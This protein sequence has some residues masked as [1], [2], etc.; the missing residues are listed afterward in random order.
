MSLNF[1]LGKKP[2]R[3]MG[4]SPMQRRLFT[5]CLMLLA[6]TL[7]MRTSGNERNWRWF[8]AMNGQP[9]DRVDDRDRKNVVRG[10]KAPVETPDGILLAQND[11]DADLADPDRY[12]PGVFPGYLESISDGTAFRA[13]DE[14]AWYHLINVLRLNDHERFEKASL[15]HHSYRQLSGQPR[16]F[17]GRVVTSAGT[18]RR[19]E[20]IPIG[21]NPYGVEGTLYRLWVF[22]DDTTSPLVVYALELPAGFPIGEKI[23]EEVEATGFFFK[24]WAYEAQKDDVP[25]VPLILGKTIRWNEPRVPKSRVHQPVAAAKPDEPPSEQR[26]ASPK[27]YMKE[28]WDGYTDEDWQALVDR[29]PTSTPDAK[30]DAAA[31]VLGRLLMRVGTFSPLDVRTWTRVDATPADLI[32]QPDRFRG[33][34]VRFDGT[35]ASYAP[36]TLPADAARRYELENFFRCELRTADGSPIIVYA[37]SVPRRWTLAK[38]EGERASVTG[39]FIKLDP[40]AEGGAAPVLVADRIG[41]HPQSFFGDLG[42][43]VGLWDRIVQRTRLT[44]AEH[45]AFYQMFTAISRVEP[46]KFAQQAHRDHLAR[47]AGVKIELP[48]GNDQPSNALFIRDVST[49]PSEHIGALGVLTGTAL[50]A[51]LIRVDDEETRRRFG[52]DHY[53]QLDVSVRLD[54]P[55]EISQPVKA[56][57]EKKS[58]H[59]D[60][61]PVVVCVREL[62]SGFPEGARIHEEVRVPAAFFKLWRVESTATAEGQNAT[63]ALPMFVARSFE[64]FPTTPAARDESVGGWITAML[65]MLGVAIVAIGLWL[66]NRRDKKIEQQL[67]EKTIALPPG[68]SL[69]DVPT[70]DTSQTPDFDAIA[71][72]AAE[73]D[74]TDDE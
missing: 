21:K 49:K 28:F 9:Q 16:Y 22:P 44:A 59:R 26:F 69:K 64:W 56:G 10:P 14:D 35:L 74:E 27:A 57:G 38:S 2:G 23:K 6:V 55:F 7:L 68:E 13:A 8:F 29:Q 42:V 48:G 71:A 3:P 66:V 70:F 32:A 24:R 18:V 4:L 58:I 1:E 39:L 36:L 30:D 60:D 20:R 65:V 41:W 34:F 72:A 12:F 43:D 25:I 61:F 33:E 17:R 19:S 53:Y 73:R 46:K 31:Q 51:E 5:L 15:G 45:E 47:Q 50:R 63:R 37:R 40:A 62:P 67:V 52:L 54:V 11:E